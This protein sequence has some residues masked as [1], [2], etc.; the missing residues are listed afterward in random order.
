MLMSGCL[1]LGKLQY[2]DFYISQLLKNPRFYLL[3]PQY[4]DKARVLYVQVK[5]QGYTICATFLSY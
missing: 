1:L 2:N 3:K 4:N 5:K